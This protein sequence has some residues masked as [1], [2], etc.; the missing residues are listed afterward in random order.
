MEHVP[1]EIIVLNPFKPK[2]V[3]RII[4]IQPKLKAY[5]VY[6]VEYV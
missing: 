1:G 6:N 5:Y 4:S 2:I 3:V